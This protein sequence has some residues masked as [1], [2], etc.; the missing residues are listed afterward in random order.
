VWNG[1]AY[2][3]VSDVSNHG[4]L[5]YIDSIDS[6]GTI[7]FYK[8]D[9]W[10][11]VP[12]NSSQL[13]PTDGYFNLT[14]MEQYNEV[15]YLDQAYMVAVDHP[16]GTSVY[17]TMVEQ[18]LDPNYMGNIY[19]I[20][21]STVQSPISAVNQDGQNVLPEI[22]KMDNVFTPG[23]NGLLSPSWNNITWNTLTL[24]LGNLTGAQQ[25]KLVVRAIVNWGTPQEYSNWV[26]EFFA[27]PVPNGTQVTPPSFMEVK[28]ANGNW[29]QVP[30]GR[31]FPLPSDG[32]PRTYVVDLTGLFPTNDYELKICNFWN[33]TFDY[34]GVDTSPQQNIIIQKINPQAYLYQAFIDDNSTPSGDFTRYGNV[35][36]LVQSGN[37]MFVIGREGDAVSLQFPISQL[38][39]V[40][41][42]MVRD[43][44]LFEACWFKDQNGNWG[45]G[46]PFTVD[47]LPFENMTSFPYP[48]NESYPNDTAHQNYLQEWDTR[49]IPPTNDA[50]STSSF[51]NANALILLA[52][53]TVLSTSAVFVAY[54]CLNCGS[55]YRFRLRK[56]II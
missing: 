9:P 50:Q 5:G 17:S 37:D 22:S 8:N 25:I 4:W 34:I 27:Q 45:F 35:T 13:Q 56:L 10:D 55:L 29:I 39:P 26:N 20:N 28:D 23:L 46:F 33:V 51:V 47:P 42:G 53:P 48:P 30:Q 2:T 14:M 43:Y 24:N 31:E 3:Y 44:F 49:I 16:V 12:L 38:A 41:Q 32:A 18:F 21:D 15:F 36:Q 7:N 11:Y 19:T 6:N 40:P 1:T 52:V 54:A